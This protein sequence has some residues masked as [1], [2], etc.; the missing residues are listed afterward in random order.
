[1]NIVNKKALKIILGSYPGRVSDSKFEYYSNKSNKIW[2]LIGIDNNLSFPEKVK[3]LE[4][5]NI[6]LWDTE[7][8]CKRISK[9]GKDSSLDKDIKDEKFNNLE[10][11]LNKEIYF[12]G[13]K[14]FK[15]FKKAIKEQDLIFKDS[16]LHLLLSSS[17]AN[18]GK[19]I[20]REIQWKE[21]FGGE[22]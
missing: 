11:L 19:K 9:N 21:A 16:Q 22:N 4:K 8:S 12:N 18:N 15:D 14:A 10:I 5:R 17:G 20:D 2:N 6:G 13:K 7:N 1:M 3:E